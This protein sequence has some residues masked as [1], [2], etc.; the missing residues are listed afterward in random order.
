MGLTE[1]RHSIATCHGDGDIAA[2][3]T[4]ELLSIPKVRT[5]IRP[6]RE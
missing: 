4:R 1:A 6:Q 2:E 5:D 3:Q